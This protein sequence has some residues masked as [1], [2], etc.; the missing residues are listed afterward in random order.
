VKQGD[1]SEG[2]HVLAGY[3]WSAEHGLVAIWLAAVVLLMAAWRR[4]EVGLGRAWC[5]LA[6]ILSLGLVM[7]VCSNVMQS[8]VVYG[9]TARM[10]VPFL[11]LLAGWAAARWVSAPGAA[12]WRRPVAVLVVLAIAAGNFLQPLRQVFPNKFIRQGNALIER[13]LRAITD[14]DERQR[15]QERMKYMYA[16]F[17]WPMPEHYDFPPYDTLLQARHPLQYD[18]YLFEGFNHEQRDA[19]HTT[20]LTMRLVWIKD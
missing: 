18:P 4:R 14:P 6:G 3:F 9:R 16:G 5:W 11:A 1:L 15:A 17:Q 2:H 12:R 7:I 10:L 20:D 13:R 19:I 8:F